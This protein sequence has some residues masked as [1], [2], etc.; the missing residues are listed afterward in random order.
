MRMFIDHIWMSWKLNVRM[1]FAFV[2]MPG[3]N[4]DPHEK[5]RLDFTNINQ[6]HQLRTGARATGNMSDEI[7]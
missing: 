4:H 3:Y 2:N 7:K 6:S 5:K 1:T